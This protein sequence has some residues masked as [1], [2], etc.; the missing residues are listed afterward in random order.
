MFGQ[1]SRK[2]KIG[3]KRSLLFDLVERYLGLWHRAPCHARG[4]AL[5]SRKCC[6][7]PHNWIPTASQNKQLYNQQYVTKQPNCSNMSKASDKSFGCFQKI[8]FWT[9]SSKSL[10]SNKERVQNQRDFWF[11]A[12]DGI[13]F[14]WRGRQTIRIEVKTHWRKAMQIRLYHSRVKGI[15]IPMLRHSSC[16]FLIFTFSNFKFEIPI[17]ANSGPII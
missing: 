3:R 12:S 5:P 2:K 16:I 1:T 17:S 7:F 14:G 11:G 9:I 6:S 8:K 4:V 13:E 15:Q 10:T